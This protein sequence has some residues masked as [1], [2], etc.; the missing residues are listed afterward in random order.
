MVEADG[1]SR[2]ARAETTGRPRLPGVLV[3]SDQGSRWVRSLL[4]AM[5]VICPPDPCSSSRPAGPGRPP[6]VTRPLLHH[7]KRRQR[8]VQ[9]SASSSDQ[10]LLLC[11][12]VVPLRALGDHSRMPASKAATPPL[13][14]S[15]SREPA[16]FGKNQPGGCALGP[17]AR[18]HFRKASFVQAWPPS[19]STSRRS[20][21]RSRWQSVSSGEPQAS[22]A[23]DA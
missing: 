12:A 11:P 9:P 1:Q 6:L 16:V 7:E 8:P 10:A 3:G 13:S 21:G 18:A 22:G 19:A 23:C 14:H 2:R 4:S 5:V 20:V 17:A 15:R